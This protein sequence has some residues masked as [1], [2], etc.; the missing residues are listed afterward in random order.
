[1]LSNLWLECTLPRITSTSTGSSGNGYWIP[2][3]GHALI[4]TVEL[5]IA[6]TRIDK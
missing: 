5:E 2:Y 1:M 3:V 6:G 4:K